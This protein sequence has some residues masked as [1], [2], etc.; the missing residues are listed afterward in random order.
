[1]RGE[2]MMI[3][4]F[5]SVIICLVFITCHVTAEDPKGPEQIHI[6]FGPSPNKM[7][8]MWSVSQLETSNVTYSPIP[9]T[10]VLRAIPHCWK[11]TK[12]NPSGLQYLCRAELNVSPGA[13]HYYIIH[14]KWGSS[15]PLNFTAMRTG[16]NWVP[17]LL[18]Y[19]DMG[20]HGGAESLGALV[21]EVEAG[22]T[23]A[24]LHVGDFAYDFDSD[25]GVNG[26]Q[27][28][29]RIQPLAAHV[30]YMTC[31]GNHEIPHDF[32]HY[33]N[34]FTMP[35][36]GHPFW[37]SWDMGPIHFIS[38]STEVYFVDSNIE[39]QY[40]WLEQD[41]IAANAAKN[42]STHPWIIAY[43]HRP[44][45]C[46]NIDPIDCNVNTSKIRLG[47]EPLFYKYGVD[48]IFTGHEHS[49]ERMWPV[50]NLEVVQ[51]DYI[52]CKAPVHIITGTAGCN[53][54]DG[55]CFTPMLRPQGPWSAYRSWS[56][57][58]H[59]YGRLKVFNGTHIRW[60]QVIALSDTLEDEVWIVKNY[61]GPYEGYPLGS[62]DLEENND[63]EETRSLPNICHSAIEKMIKILTFAIICLVFITCHVTAED[64]KGPEQIHISFGPS[65]NKMYVMWS[66]SQLGTSNVTY[67]PQPS[68]I[69]L[70]AIPH[71]W[72]FTKGNPSGLQ[73]LCRAE[74]DVT[75]GA[76][77]DYIIHCEWGSSAPLNFT[78]MRTGQNWAPR[79]LV[80]GDM[81]KHGGAESLGPLTGEVKTGDT[82]AILHIGDF[83]YDFDSD[84]GVNGDQFMNRI[85]PVAAHVAY[86]T[87]PGNHEIPHD[88]SHYLNRFTMPSNGHPF[89]Y[90]WDMGPI[91]FISFS[92]EVYFV[93][94]NIEE[95]YKWLEQDLIAA[96]A[97]AN[98]STHP[99]IIAYGHR[100]FYCSNT[101]PTD[102]NVTASKIRL[103][104]EPL[105]YKYG[106]DIIFT[107]H[108]HSYER[109]WPVYNLEVVQHDYINCKAPVH[110]IT[111]TA[112]CNELDGR[113]FT[114][115][116][117][118][119]GLWSAYRSWS[120][121]KHGYGRLKVFNGTHIRWEQVIALSDTVEDEVWIVKNYHGPY[122][123]YP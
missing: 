22:D 58:K 52:N 122:E 107:G 94:S 10:L 75:P 45:Y 56:P 32:S 30:A 95:Q 92:T 42:R 97:A 86:M 100:P 88:F 112:G 13:M 17:R 34:R 105:F 60:E 41:L 81:G 50:Y 121:G 119:Q 49:Y 37:Y 54:L 71:C 93:N 116:L 82:H 69:V 5:T 64:P 80:Y 12:G 106:V 2:I 99:W 21:S 29:N 72:K 44:F 4:M 123:G 117:Q 46:S 103:G 14:C 40:K 77:H 55:K 96:N 15:R 89:W 20:K 39:E 83:A 65:P 113:C 43:G 114:P 28:M 16:Q 79:L 11:F 18:V 74:L 57:G 91:H 67:T 47:L 98:R 87:C 68:A 53:E 9:T 108:E 111:G 84:G 25:G 73:Y 24:I 7:Y 31:P 26:D 8:V 78:A 62:S 115:M 23:H 51:H 27:F 90:S 48:I 110:F 109:M 38:F 61:H 59:G 118:P 104:L 1:M 36:N 66:V 63:V 101:D 70:M 3:K 76:M 6:S 33:L 120:P 85:Q 102:C 35:S 19:G